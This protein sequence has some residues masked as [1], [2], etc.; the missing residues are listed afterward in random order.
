M[1]IYINIYIYISFLF[2]SFSR[3][4]AIE[5]AL[6]IS[7]SPEIPCA[8]Q[9]HCVTCSFVIII[10]IIILLYYIILYYYFRL[11]NVIKLLAFLHWLHP[12][13][14]ECN[15]FGSTTRLNTV[16]LLYIIFK[17]KKQRGEK[18]NSV[19]KFVFIALCTTNEYEFSLPPFKEGF[20]AVLRKGSL[21]NFVDRH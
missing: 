3:C 14:T 19:Q 10:I 21:V 4:H 1:Y 20:S 2:F 18:E 6:F 11:S 9:I 5:R 13:C 8:F 16:T 7:I 12:T 15:F 17:R